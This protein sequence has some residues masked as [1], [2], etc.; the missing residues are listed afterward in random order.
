MTIRFEIK[1]D[2]GIS[3]TFKWDITDDEYLALSSDQKKLRQALRQYGDWIY[4]AGGQPVQFE[5]RNHWLPKLEQA[6]HFEASLLN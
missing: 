2:T 6:Q 4:E 5:Y 3:G 1:T